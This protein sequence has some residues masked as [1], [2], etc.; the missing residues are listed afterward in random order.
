MENE[1]KKTYFEE[2]VLPILKYIGAIGATVLSIAYIV[3]VVILILGF[4][5]ED[6]LNTTIF[7]IVSAGFGF[8]IMQFL[9]YQGISFAEEKEENQAILKEYYGTKTRDK[10]NHSLLYFWITTGT[11]DFIIKAGTIAFTS[12]GLIYI[13]IKGSKDYSLIGLAI[14]N[15][16]MF[17]SFGFLALVKAYNYFNR[18]YI[19]YIKERLAESK[20]DLE[21][22]R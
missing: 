14:V 20:E 13:I 21:N 1:N 15:L 6:L 4:K 22:G 16:L 2:K 10:K 19:E 9:K 8:V 17:I 3:L 11:K 12:V 18:T 5:K 7:A